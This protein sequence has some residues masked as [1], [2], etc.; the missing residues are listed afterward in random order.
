MNI[1]VEKSIKAS[2][3]KEEQS[4]IKKVHELI[5]E[6]TDTMAREHL[7]FIEIYENIYTFK[8]LAALEEQ[9]WVMF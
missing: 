9:L 1:T 4:M 3:T 7:E 6:I 8:E 2:F 5:D